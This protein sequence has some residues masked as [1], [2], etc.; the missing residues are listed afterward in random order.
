MNKTRCTHPVTDTY[1]H[2]H[3]QIERD[4][5][6]LV[7]WI[8]RYVHTAAE[9]LATSHVFVGACTSQYAAPRPPFFA[10]QLAYLEV[11]ELC[12]IGRSHG[13]EL[14]L[15]VEGLPDACRRGG[16]VQGLGGNVGAGDRTSS[17]TTPVH[18]MAIHLRRQ[19]TACRPD[20]C[21]GTDITWSVPM[22]ER[23]GCGFVNAVRVLITHL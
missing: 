19:Q 4:S 21:D 5:W 3:V 7:G 13:V 18:N 6:C 22:L 2:Q 9:C 1:P 10:W 20:V 14:V 23:F 12:G 17:P 11:Q 16:E 8:F 15:W